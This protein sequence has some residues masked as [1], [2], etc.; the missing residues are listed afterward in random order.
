MAE[1][2]AAPAS[3]QVKLVLLGE[4]EAP[5]GRHLLWHSLLRPSCNMKGASM[6]YI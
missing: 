4:D 3:V 5:V 6:A 2:A 1:A